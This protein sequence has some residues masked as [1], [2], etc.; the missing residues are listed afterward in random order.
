MES[1]IYRLLLRWLEQ[2]VPCAMATLVKAEGSVPRHAGAKMLIRADGVTEGTIGGGALEVAVLDAAGEVIRR[3]AP[4]LVSF[5]LKADLGMECGGGAEVFIEPLTPADRLY[6]FGGGHVGRALCPLAAAIGFV[7]TVIDE[8]TDYAA[9]ERF[10]EASAFVHSY[11]P[12]QWG[13]LV[14]DQSTFCVVM[15]PSHASD[16][17]LVQTL[18]RRNPRYLGMIGSP[19]KRKV[20]EKMLQEDGCGPELLA[21]LHTPVGLPIGAETPGEIAISIVAELVQ[22]RRDKKE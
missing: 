19:R 5:K 14:F 4:E 8:R 15:T 1:G 20:L 9:P 7:V 10:P 13:E 16:A 3:G 6:L 22:T 17:N 2:G 18:I 12:E 21:R 11:D